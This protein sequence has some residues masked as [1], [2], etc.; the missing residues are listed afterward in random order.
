MNPYVKS[1]LHR[2]LMFGGFG[3][4]VAGIVFFILS[5]TAEGFS[6]TGEHILLAIASTYLLAFI[7]AGATVFNQVEH[8]SVGKALLCH[9]LTLYASYSACYLANTW[10]PFHPT[11]L[12]VFTAIFAILFFAIWLTVFLIVRSTEKRLNKR[13]H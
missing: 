1:F 9:F 4:L 10:I 8:W 5:R 11:V 3:P 2:G 13:L 6:L 7:Q 12:L